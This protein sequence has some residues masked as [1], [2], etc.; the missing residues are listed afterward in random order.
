MSGETMAGFG[1]ATERITLPQRMDLTAAAP[2]AGAIAA[3]AGKAVELD[4]GSVRHLG[5]L[6]LQLLLA[7]GQQWRRDGVP[8]HLAQPS[9]EFLQTLKLFGVDAAQIENG[10]VG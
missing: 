5:G 6:G 2:V 8:L 4:A 1:G 3:A 9:E 10:D 7:A